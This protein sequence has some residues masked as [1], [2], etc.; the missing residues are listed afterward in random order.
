[1]I[2]RLIN[3]LQ[4]SKQEKNSTTKYREIPTSTITPIQEIEMRA[5]FTRSQR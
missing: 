1:M 3:T 4:R 2:K 5:F